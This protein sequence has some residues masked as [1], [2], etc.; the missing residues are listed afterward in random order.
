MKS[1]NGSRCDWGR[2]LVYLLPSPS[3]DYFDPLVGA[4]ASAALNIRQVSNQELV[5]LRVQAQEVVD[6]DSEALG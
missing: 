4:V 3:L 2:W 5:E 6:G 1:S